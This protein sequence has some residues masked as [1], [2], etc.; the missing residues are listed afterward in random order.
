MEVEQRRKKAADPK[1]KP[2]VFSE[3]DKD[4]DKNIVARRKS[5][6]VAVG[7][8]VKKETKERGP[9]LDVDLICIRALWNEVAGADAGAASDI[10]SFKNG[11]LTIAIRSSTLLQEM[12]QFRQAELL[13]SLRQKWSAATPLLR[14]EF[15]A[16]TKTRKER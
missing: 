7:K 2:W 11:I 5:D 13:D 1:K 10:Y 16:G 8:L 4:G 12:R 6:P 3:F 14:L 15:R 9:G